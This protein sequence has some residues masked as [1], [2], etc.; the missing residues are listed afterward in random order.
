MLTA[1][2]PASREFVSTGA[3]ILEPAV[4]VQ[5][6]ELHE[7]RAVRRVRPEV[8]LEATEVQAIDRGHRLHEGF[9]R[10]MRSG[11]FQP[12]GQRLRREERFEA[13][14]AQPSESFLAAK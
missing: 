10:G 11:A 5:D 1:R 12:F 4:L 8:E 3:S 2:G 9:L 7:F 6:G 14:V 13:R